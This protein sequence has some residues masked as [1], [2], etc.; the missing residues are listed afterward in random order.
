MLED[1]LKSR[2]DPN[3]ALAAPPPRMAPP[4]A[5]SPAALPPA[6]G[7]YDPVGIATSFYSALSEA[8]GRAAVALVVPEKRGTGAYVE[9]NIN[10]FYASLREPLKILSI[11][12]IDADHVSV[13]YSFTRRS[14]SVCVGDAKVNTAFQNGRTFIKGI[15]ANC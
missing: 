13:R 1:Q 9:A 7:T 14:G 3:A 12:R 6:A 8:N 2:D 5:T 4:V 11:E 15:A 10:K